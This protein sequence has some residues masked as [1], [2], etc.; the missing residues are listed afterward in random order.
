MTS[1]LGEKG[2]KIIITCLKHTT[3]TV[4]LL[5][6]SLRSPQQSRCSVATVPWCPTVTGCA[7]TLSQTTFYSACPAF[8]RARKRARRNSP[9]L[10]RRVCWTW[11]TCATHATPAPIRPSEER[12]RRW[13]RRRKRT[14]TGRAERSR[15]PPT[16]PKT[17]KR[18]RRFWWG[19]QTRP[20]RRLRRRPRHRQRQP[21]LW[22]R[23]EKL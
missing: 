20:K 6:S 9:R 14:R 13:R 1:K 19:R 5:W 16:W 8:A 11:G 4:L 3:K 21:E 12:L 18:C 23:L 17:S 22:R 7:T 10:W 15:D 2:G